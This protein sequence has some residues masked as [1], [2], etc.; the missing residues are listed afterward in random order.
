MMLNVSSGEISGRQNN[1]LRVQKEISEAFGDANIW[2]QGESAQL[3]EFP[4]PEPASAT[5]LLFG[6]ALTLAARRRRT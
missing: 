4:I 6:S 5:L 3:A 1:K 2:M